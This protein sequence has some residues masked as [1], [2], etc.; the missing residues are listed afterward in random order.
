MRELKHPIQFYEKARGKQFG[1]M[2]ASVRDKLLE[3]TA[4]HAVGHIGFVHP[5]TRE[6]PDAFAECIDR[7]RALLLALEH[8]W[9][10]DGILKHDLLTTLGAFKDV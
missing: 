2:V 1:Q 4:T 7:A 3:H 6:Y 8:N 5:I 9:P 10:D